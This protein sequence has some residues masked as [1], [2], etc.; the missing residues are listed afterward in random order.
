MVCRPGRTSRSATTTRRSRSTSCRFWPV[1][2]R[3][4]AQQRPSDLARRRGWKGGRGGEG[5]LMAVAAADVIDDDTLQGIRKVWTSADP[6]TLPG[7]V[8]EPIQAGRLKSTPDQLLKMPY[9][10]ASCELAKREL[11][12]TG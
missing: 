8:A 5:K 7:L 2:G 11:S 9:A 10:Q 1:R 3:G 12:G 4:D 6:D